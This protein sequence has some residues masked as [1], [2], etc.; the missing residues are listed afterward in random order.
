M[1]L[2]L[3]DTIAAIASPPGSGLRGIVRMSGAA[4]HS[5][6]L[7]GFTPQDES[8]WPKRA[9]RR[10]GSYR[11]DG[12]RPPLPAALILWPGRRSYT[13]QPSAEIHTV[14]SPP[15]LQLL[16]AQCVAKGARL[17][18]PGEFTLRAFLS[19][20][21]DLTRA[22]AVLGVIDARTLAQLDSAL[23]QLA[24]GLA[25]PIS[26]LRDQMLDL[27]A[28]IEANLDFVDEADVDPLGRRVLAEGLAQAASRLAAM[29]VRMVA[30]DRP[31]GHPKVVLVGPPNAGKSQL[32]NA[33]TGQHHA[34]VSPLPGTTRDYLSAP[35]DC[36]GLMIDLIDTAGED[37]AHS[38]IEETAQALRAGQVSAA[39]LLLVC[40][41]ADAL[42]L[43]SHPS[44]LAIFV[45]TKC[46]LQTARPQHP[47][48]FSTSALNG[49]GLESLRSAIAS[50]IRNQ[51]G[52]DNLAATTGARC[53]GSLLLASEALGSAA[54]TVALGG[55]DE[56]VAMDLRQAID[57]LGKVVGA[58]VTD[59]I[60]DRIFQR[61]CIGK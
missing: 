25:S 55:G 21:I 31:L 38:T 56:L 48:T 60:L 22:E 57:E 4:A 16:L 39:D 10:S 50:T 12:L 45:Q 36:D 59:D 51:D 7:M 8:P 9:E 37:A 30:R 18:E 61:F 6:A 58:V 42:E 5:L 15:L 14:G 47:Q 1:I 17:A 40:T 34:L 41:P 3:S 26:A 49:Q 46:D 35:C 54:Q 43:S 20:R 11:L 2:D 53:Q 44:T 27:L 24:G 28:H 23:Q 19:G 13:G 32:F 33:L 29:A 52:E